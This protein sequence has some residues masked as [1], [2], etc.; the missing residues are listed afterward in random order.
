MTVT[1]TRVSRVDKFYKSFGIPGENI[2]VYL[3]D[4]TKEQMKE[5]LAKYEVVLIRGV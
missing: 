4:V 5:M 3:K 1:K 2:G